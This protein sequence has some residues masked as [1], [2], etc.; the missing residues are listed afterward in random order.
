MGVKADIDIQRWGF[1]PAG[2]GE[3]SVT[4]PGQP[5]A[6]HA[7]TLLDRGTL[8]DVWG[9]AAVTE[10]PSHIP[11]RMATRAENVLAQEGLRARVEPR[12]LRGAGPGAGIFLFSKYRPEDDDP[13]LAGFTAYGRK[14][15]PAE[16]VA[17]AACE[18]LLAHHRGQAAVDPFL[19][20]QLVLPMALASSP[21]RFRTSKITQH[22]LTNAWV[23]RQFV[24]VD[25]AIEGTLG[26][27]GD[28]TISGQQLQ[29]AGHETRGR[30]GR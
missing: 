1:Y 18:E 28:V 7:I 15:L 27:P 30:R 19:A 20:D 13:T 11:Q 26:G 23:V 6:L 8:E 4:I 17:E 25:I 29:P 5:G 2:G 14:G 24:P 9:I 10:L 21:S 3:L 12:R 22:L 16:H